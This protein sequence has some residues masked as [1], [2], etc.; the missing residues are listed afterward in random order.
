MYNSNS[1]QC[2][3]SYA[4]FWLAFLKYTIAF[5]SV[6]C[7]VLTLSSIRANTGT[8]ANSVDP[9]EPA[10]DEPSSGST[11]FAILLLIFDWNPYLQ[12]WT[13][14]NSKM[15]E[16][17]SETQG[18]RIIKNHHTAV[19]IFIFFKITEPIPVSWKIEF[20]SRRCLRSGGM[21]E[22]GRGAYAAL[23]TIYLLNE[24]SE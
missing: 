12:Q 13:C 23:Q 21:R 15:Q 20:R 17:M 14:P 22:W 8:F 10:R 24:E 19:C 18:E 3:V 7:D 2:I 6:K 11:L 4:W 1:N 9:D 16:S 5:E